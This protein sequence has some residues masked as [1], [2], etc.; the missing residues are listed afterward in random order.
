MEVRDTRDL[1][2]SDP[3]RSDL[4]RGFGDTLA[5]SFELVVTPMVFGLVGWLVDR[6]L[7]T[8][9]LFALVLGVVAVV[10]M[11]L[12]MYFGYQDDMER[13]ERDAP[14]ARP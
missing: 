1:S 2:G 11:M 10:G 12:R 6:W 9:P 7:G 8:G 3:S 14:W 5:R 13:Q 4:Y